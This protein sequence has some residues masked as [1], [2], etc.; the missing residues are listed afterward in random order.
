MVLTACRCHYCENQQVTPATLGP[1][2][3]RLCLQP[4]DDHAKYSFHMTVSDRHNV[5]TTCCQSICIQQLKDD[6]PF[7]PPSLFWQPCIIVLHSVLTACSNIQ[8]SLKKTTL[9]LFPVPRSFELKTSEQS[10]LINN[11]SVHFLAAGFSLHL[12][13]LKL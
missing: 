10:I 13:H 5:K 8:G 7:N 6:P 2:V 9:M 3:Y 4:A 12:Y 1:T 11:I